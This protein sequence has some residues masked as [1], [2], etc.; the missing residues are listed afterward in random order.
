MYMT[1]LCTEQ[2][3]LKIKENT[4]WRCNNKN[5]DVTIRQMKAVENIG[6]IK[7][8]SCSRSQKE[9]QIDP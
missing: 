9:S 1:E 2:Y 6:R 7:L 8:K 4:N 5:L 3:F